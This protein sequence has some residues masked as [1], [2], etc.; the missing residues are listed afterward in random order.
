MESRYKASGDG[1]KENERAGKA[2]GECGEGKGEGWEREGES[3]KVWRK[4]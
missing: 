4:M 3:G 1:S 2:K